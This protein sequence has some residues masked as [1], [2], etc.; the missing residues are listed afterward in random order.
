[1]RQRDGARPACEDAAPR[2]CSAAWNKVLLLGVLSGFLLRPA[3]LLGGS[4]AGASFGAQ[5]AFFAGPIAK[6]GSRDAG[7]TRALQQ[8]AHFFQAADL[9]VNSS[10]K[11]FASHFFSLYLTCELIQGT[12]TTFLP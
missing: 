5:H 11:F 2:H 1:M 4:D 8:G 6:G 10:N 12:D 3:P 7:T 9:F